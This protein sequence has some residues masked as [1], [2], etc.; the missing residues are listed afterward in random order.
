MEGED[1]GCAALAHPALRNMP[2]W[3]K[4]HHPG[5]GLSGS[6]ARGVQDTTDPS[7]LIGWDGNS[8]SIGSTPNKVGVDAFFQ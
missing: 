2:G 6:S 4:W 3:R 7:R 8:I 1:W 5:F